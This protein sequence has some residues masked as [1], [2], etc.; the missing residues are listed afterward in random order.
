[1]AEARRFFA[2]LAWTRGG[3]ARDV[4][5][6]AGADGAWSQV[7]GG[8]GPAERAGNRKWSIA[9]PDNM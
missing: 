4:L 2:P 1:M 6:V 5:L 9:P 7:R 8:C 3:W